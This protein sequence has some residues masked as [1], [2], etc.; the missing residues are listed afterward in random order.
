MRPESPVMRFGRREVGAGAPLFVIAEIGLNHGGSVERALALVD[1]AADAGADAIKLQTIVADELVAP[2][3]P[4]PA[5]VDA[6]S[7]VDFFATFELSE[8]AHERIAARAWSRGLVVLATPFSERAVDM[9]LRVGID[10]F[11]IASGDLT[12][13]QLIARTAA[14]AKPVVMSTG[15]AT[16]D[17]TAA[18]VAVAREAGVSSLALLHCVSAYPVP[19]GEENLRAIDT[20]GLQFDL[21]VGLSD[22][23]SD[24][25][26]VPM[27][28]ALGASLYERH[29]ILEDDKD[30]N[31]AV[32]L[33]VSSRPSELAAA[34]ALARRAHQ[35]L[36]TGAKDS[37]GAEGANRIASRRSLCAV[38]D[39]P[40]G[41]TISSEDL[42]ALRPA[43]GL[44]PFDMPR[45]VGLTLRH[46][47]RRG[48]AL[49]YDDLYATRRAYAS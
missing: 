43:T 28:V 38:R 4:A 13:H 24:A 14:T 44:A 46:S 22:H 32:D 18:A 35:S 27:A 2:T 41:H 17:E 11:K 20:L 26:A 21:P 39:L 3:C 25:F 31:D 8:A 12:W 49:R 40:Q 33:A 36:G 5:H 15:L 10:G 23:G 1:A 42:I 47:V 19:P 29:L 7:L 6:T 34:I 9:L 48:H 16:F 30:A 45:I 37:L